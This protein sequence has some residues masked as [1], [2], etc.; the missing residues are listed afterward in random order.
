MRH[1]LHPRVWPARVPEQRG[2]RV[3]KLRQR[4]L[5]L[6]DQLLRHLLGALQPKKLGVRCLV[7]RLVLP[8]SLTKL[9]R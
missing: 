7:D 5:R 6:V 8:G 9:L 1:T 2:R 4:R 3:A